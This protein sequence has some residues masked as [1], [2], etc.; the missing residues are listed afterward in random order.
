MFQS[1]ITYLTTIFKNYVSSPCQIS[2]N[3]CMVVTSSDSEDD[4]S[5]PF[6]TEVKIFGALYAGM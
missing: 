3:M 6:N 1:A 2:G 5:F 4:Y